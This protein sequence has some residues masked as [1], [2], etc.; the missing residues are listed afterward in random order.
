MGGCR[1]Q[2]LGNSLKIGREVE[3]DNTLRLQVPGVSAH[4]AEILKDQNSY[5]LK[6]CMSTNG[7][8][9]NGK[10]MEEKRILHNGDIIQIQDVTLICSLH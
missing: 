10:K 2:P 6:D 4:H 8:F 7:S 5:S 1:W 9:V 3:G